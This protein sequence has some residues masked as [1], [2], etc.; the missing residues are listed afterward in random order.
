MHTKAA[1]TDTPRYSNDFQINFV[2][3]SKILTKKSAF[4]PKWQRRKSGQTNG[5]QDKILVIPITEYLWLALASPRSSPSW[6][7]KL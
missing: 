4:Y 1:N 6:K 5:P 3:V 2:L 7:C